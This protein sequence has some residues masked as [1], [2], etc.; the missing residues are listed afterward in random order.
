MNFVDNEIN[1]HSGTIRGRAIFD[2]KDHFL[3]PGTFGR[4]R[5]YG[6]PLDAL[7]IPDAAVV[8]DQASKVVLTVGADNKVVAK[9]VTLGGMA[10]GL[11][12]IA[13]GLAPTD[14]VVIGGL[15]N[16]F[17]R[18]GVDGRR[19]ARR[20]DPSSPD[21]QLR[22]GPSKPMRFSHFFIDRPIFAAVL[23]IILTIAGALVERA[24]P[25]SEYPE[26]APP[27]VSIRATYP[28]ASAEVL[29][30][31][32]R[33]ADRA[34]GE[35]RRQHALH[36]LAV[37]R[38]RHADDQRRVQAGHRHRYRAGA[39]AEPR[40]GRRAAAA[41]RRAA[42]R[43]HGAQGVARPDDGR[44][45]D[46]AGRLARPAV[47]LQLRDALHQGRAGARRRRRRRQRVRRAR[48]LDADLA[49]SRQGRGAR[50]DRGRRGRGAAR[51]QPPGR[52]RRD[53]PAAG[54]VAR[55]VPA[56]GADARAGCRTS[57][58]SATSWCAPIRRHRLRAHPRH[59][60]RRARLAGLHGQRLSQQGRG[61]RDRDLSSARARTRW[62]PRPRV[63]ADDGGGEAGFPARPRLHDRLQ[64]DRVHPAVDRRGGA[65][66]VRGDRAGGRA[67]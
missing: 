63:Q 32:R 41:G 35:R 5:L 7:L 59:R 44:A 51:G 36:H 19:R 1:A 18:P 16:P 38:R 29:A 66:A 2:N 11:R 26:I 22:R 40:L 61:D 10:R 60:P 67:W 8:S 37:G 46:L 14:R 58:S 12:V 50:P 4:L 45:H 20:D 64:P 21:S 39:G 27:T 30:A 56:L 42:A 23:S 15:A 17:V 31:D 43:R 28:G 47:H 3:T 24:L 65:D 52:G 34:G 48:L 13:S 55:R 49:R 9:P 25:I 62:Q 6:G 53:Q 33:H 57:S 54:D